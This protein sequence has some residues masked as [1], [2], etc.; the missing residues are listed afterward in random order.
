MKRFLIIQFVLLFPFM[1]RAQIKH[2]HEYKTEKDIRCG[3]EQFTLYLND[4]KGKSVGVLTNHTGKIR[5]THLVDTL[6]SL[7][8]NVRKVFGPEHGFRGDASAGKSVGNFKDEKTGLPVISLY[9]D[10]KKPTPE[11]LSG[12][13]VVLID[14]QDV[15]VRFYTYISS[16][17]FMME[18]C[19]EVNIPVI[20]LD[21]PNPNGHYVDGPVLEKG[22]E[23]FVGMHPVPIVHG[24]TMGEYAR[25]VNGEKW[26]KNNLQAKLKIIPCMGWKHSDYYKLPVKPSPNLKTM[27]SIYLYPTLCLFEGTVMSVGRGTDKPFQIVGHPLLTDAP[28]KFTP[29]SIPGESDNPK[30]N[31]KECYGYDLTNFSVSYIREHKQ[32]YLF[33]LS[34]MYKRFPDKAS[35][36]TSY[37]DKLAGNSTLR[38]QIT[39]GVPE[40]K[41]RESWKPGLESFLTIRKKYLLYD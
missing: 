39:E 1:L 25:M 19:A 8:V 18:A 20:V 15:G 13:Q 7:G 22:F 31:G 40:D 35:F 3:A 32:I 16:M 5:H 12:I 30:F 38:K 6:L 21:R 14:L 23:S 26:L 37:F 9:G 4:L 11:D 27:E 17:T 34:D 36:F 24:M 33:W 28:Y 41:I 10:H 2:D 29:K